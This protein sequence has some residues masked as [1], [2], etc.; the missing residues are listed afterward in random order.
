MEK[1]LQNES[2]LNELNPLSKESLKNFAEYIKQNKTIVIKESEL[3]KEEKEKL[4]PGLITFIDPE[5]F[6]RPPQ[7]LFVDKNL[8]MATFVFETHIEKMFGLKKEAYVSDVMRALEKLGFDISLTNLQVQQ[9][10]LDFLKTIFE[11]H[12]NSKENSESEIKEEED[13]KKEFD[14]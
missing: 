6:M 1:F 12:T 11:K 3:N 8:N 7:M 9:A 13:E 10:E 2:N 14:F 5:N 4:L